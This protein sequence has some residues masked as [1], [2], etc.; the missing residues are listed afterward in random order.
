MNIPS[1]AGAVKFLNRMF[2][3]K[4]KIEFFY[5]VENKQIGF[6]SP[7]LMAPRLPL[8]SPHCGAAKIM[9]HSQSKTSLVLKIIMLCIWREYKTDASIARQKQAGAE[10]TAR[11]TDSAASRTTTGTAFASCS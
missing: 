1:N 10:D 3:K 5:I 7:M 2:S 4:I 6:I 9:V 11:S 8:T